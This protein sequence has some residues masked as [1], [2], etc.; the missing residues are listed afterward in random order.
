MD[1]PLL[2]VNGFAVIVTDK[3]G[4]KFIRTTAHGGATATVCTNPHADSI[5]HSVSFFYSKEIAECYIP[6]TIDIVRR[7][8]TW[9][10][11]PF[12]AE[13]VPVKFSIG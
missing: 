4:T 13:V 7:D 2:S 12:K 6:D 10:I 5:F 9:T 8:F 3:D 1:K 11:P